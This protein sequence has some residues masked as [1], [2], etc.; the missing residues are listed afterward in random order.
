VQSGNPA[1]AS[2]P[3]ITAAYYIP[4]SW[5]HTDFSAVVRPN[6]EINDGRFISRSFVGYGAHFG[7]DVKPGWFGWSKDDITFHAALGDG[8]GTYLQATGA[9]S[10]ATNYLGN[11]Q[12]ISGT[13]GSTTATTT[14]TIAA[15]K[16]AANN[17][18]AKTIRRV[19]GEIGYQH[20]WTADLRQNVS[21][22]WVHADTPSNLIG[23]TAASAVNKD[24]SIVRTNLIWRPV[25]FIDVGIEYI[26]GH[27]VTVN[28]LRGDQHVL[29]SK[30]DL[31]F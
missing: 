17:V 15:Q 27:R 31:K 20:W 13:N 11:G 7:A 1:K 2:A 25:A 9:T 10:V 21:A 3:T 12:V 8:I 30:F 6:L 22:G 4:Q 14:G 18:L 28:N 19:G 23:A 5:G 29:V 26:W 24:L 16:A